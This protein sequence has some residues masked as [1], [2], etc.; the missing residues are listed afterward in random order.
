MSYITKDDFLNHIKLKDL[1]NLCM[2]DDNHPDY[3]KLTKAINAADSLIDS[4]LRSATTLPL[5]TVPENVKLCSYYIATHILHDNIQG[6][7][8]PERVEKNYD[9]MIKWLTD[10]SEGNVNLNVDTASAGVWYSAEENIINS[11]MY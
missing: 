10:V 9:R 2:G 11:N 3:N 1:D 5:I 7:D 8:V 6:G 4:Y